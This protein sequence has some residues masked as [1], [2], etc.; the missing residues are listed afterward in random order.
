MCIMTLP[1]SLKISM[2]SLGHLLYNTFQYPNNM[3]LKNN[4]PNGNH[5][6]ISHKHATW[7]VDLKCISPMD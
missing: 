3:L 5:M 1:A 2:Y 4:H 7:E 6:V